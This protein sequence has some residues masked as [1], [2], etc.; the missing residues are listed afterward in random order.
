MKHRR[1]CQESFNMTLSGGKKW[2]LSGRNGYDI[3]NGG[4][5]CVIVGPLAVFTGDSVPNWQ[6]AFLCL[7]PHNGQY[8]PA[9][10][11]LRCSQA[12]A[13]HSTQVGITFNRF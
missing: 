11:C 10:L 6:A 9:F 12:L 8:L 2:A 7:S 5:E 13:D 4:G 3:T 1:Y